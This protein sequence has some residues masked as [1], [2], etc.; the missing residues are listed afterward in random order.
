[1]STLASRKLVGNGNESVLLHE[2]NR[3]HLNPPRSGLRT[4]RIKIPATS[5]SV[6]EAQRTSHAVFRTG[7]VPPLTVQRVT[8]PDSLDLGTDSN[9]TVRLSNSQPSQ[10]KAVIERRVSRP[11]S[12]EINGACSAR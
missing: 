4:D 5:S 3:T 6:D 8:P 12:Y 11:F 9:L 2:P 10:P 1:M 7:A